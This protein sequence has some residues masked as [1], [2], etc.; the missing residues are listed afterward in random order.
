M[1]TVRGRESTPLREP[2]GSSVEIRVW[3][4]E[5][6]SV[7][8]TLDGYT[9]VRDGVTGMLSYA[10]LSAD[11]TELVSTGVAAGEPAPARG[12][13]KHI[14]ITPEATRAQ[15]LKVREDFE[16]HGKQARQIVFEGEPFTALNLIRLR[17]RL[18]S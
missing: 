18:E 7:G 4:D 10:E 13:A 5:F 2:D 9:I 11:G 16:R 17:D 6:Y 8:E 1:F 14:R 3:G 15:A 12:L